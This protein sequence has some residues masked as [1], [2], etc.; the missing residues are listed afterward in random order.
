MNSK[1]YKTIF[2]GTP[3]FAVPVLKILATLPYLKI[4]AVVTQQDKPIG[5]KQIIT[6]SPVKIMAE[7]NN[8]P[9]LQ[10]KKIKTEEFEEKLRQLNP[11]VAIIV[12]YGKI[13]P[14]NLLNIPQHG[15]LNIHASLLPKYRG[16]SPIQGAI[17]NGEETTGVSLMKIDAGLDSGPVISQKRITI[18]QSDNSQTLHNKLSRLGAELAEKALLDYLEGKIKPQPQDNSK[19]TETKII[20]KE[21]GQIDWS[22]QAEFIE[23]Q[24]RAFTPW[25]GA[26]CF[27]NDK[28]LKII[29]ATIYQKSDQLL[30]G[31]TKEINSNIIAGCG[32]GN[33]ELK[34]IQLEGKK[35]QPVS[36]FIKG[37]PKF[38]QTKLS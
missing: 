35:R 37:Y 30:P 5:K 34:T 10:P 15:W 29:E 25:P 18:E 6:P 27:W 17:L 7:K 16:A 2:F 22:K 28:R 3:E 9:V 33:L 8:I 23:R 11:D 13:I 19:A 4:K 36:A 32:K 1:I 14:K 21:D 38:G 12:A 31:L 26:F 24:I 20:K